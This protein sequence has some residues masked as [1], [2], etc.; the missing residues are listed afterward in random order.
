MAKLF[1]MGR[2]GGIGGILWLVGI[3]VAIIAP[4]LAHFA[5]IGVIA[6]AIAWP[7]AAVISIIVGALNLSKKEKLPFVL[8][9]GVFATM[10]LAGLAGNISEAVPMIGIFLE[11][12][13]AGLLALTGPAA[14]ITGFVLVHGWMKGKNK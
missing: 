11:I 2:L 13:L 10:G 1:K 7:L 5:G 14:I 3:F 8:V 9:T 12:T 6:N 4:L